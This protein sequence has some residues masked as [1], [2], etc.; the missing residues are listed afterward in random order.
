MDVVVRCPVCR[1]RDDR[2]SSYTAIRVSMTDE[3]MEHFFCKDCQTE[4]HREPT[5]KEDPGIGCGYGRVVRWLL[6]PL[7]KPYLDLCVKHDDQTSFNS[8]AQR[9]GIPSD[10]IV[11]WW[12]DGVEYIGNQPHMKRQGFKKMVGRLSGT[13]IHWVNHLFYEKPK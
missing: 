2:F 11:E 6:K 9:M 3:G 1:D 5:V 10:K 13:V 4:F 12:K 7:M 8:F